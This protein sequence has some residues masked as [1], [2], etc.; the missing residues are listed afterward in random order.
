MVSSSDFPPKQFRLNRA[1]GMLNADICILPRLFSLRV[2]NA[3]NVR[4]HTQRVRYIESTS[5]RAAM[6]V[7]SRPD[8]LMISVQSFP[9]VGNHLSWGF[10]TN[11]FHRG[12][13]QAQH[14]MV[15]D[16]VDRHSIGYVW[17]PDQYG[18]GPD[19]WQLA[20]A[21]TYVSVLKLFVLRNCWVCATFPYRCRGCTN[22]WSAGHLLYACRVLTCAPDKRSTG[23]QF[24]VFYEQWGSQPC[25]EAHLNAVLV[26]GQ[27]A[28]VAVAGSGM[29]KQQCF[30]P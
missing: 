19:D 18:P 23:T 29:L 9:V 2:H 25:W 13:L 8:M 1:N 22:F 17:D 3:D 26:A 7:G 16:P 28:E 6:G 21:P 24:F 5:R 30:L 27:H 4:S 15:N 11:R 14:A 20:S 12:K 10:G